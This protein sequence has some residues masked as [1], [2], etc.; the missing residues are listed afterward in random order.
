MLASNL[1][2]YTRVNILITVINNDYVIEHGSFSCSAKL[3]F[4]VCRPGGWRSRRGR[5]E[6]ESQDESMHIYVS[7]RGSFVLY[8]LWLYN[9]MAAPWSLQAIQRVCSSFRNLHKPVMVYRLA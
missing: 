2:I 6:T 8:Y 7:R 3:S 1:T 4:D 5:G 9:N